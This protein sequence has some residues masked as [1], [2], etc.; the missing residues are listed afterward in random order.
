SSDLYAPTLL[1]CSF[2]FNRLASVSLLKLSLI[3]YGSQIIHMACLADDSFS[4][5]SYALHVSVN[6]RTHAL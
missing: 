3:D 4:Q 2:D 5:L 6:R 1:N